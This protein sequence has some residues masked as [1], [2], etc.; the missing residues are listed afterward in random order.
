MAVA[1]VG[2]VLSTADAATGWSGVTNIDTD[3]EV[4]GTGCL[5]TKVSGATTAATFSSSQDLSSNGYHVVI[6]LNCTT[7]SLD[8]KANG[9]LR[10][11]LVDAGGSADWYVGGED[12]RKAGWGAYIIDPTSTANTGSITSS[13]ITALGGVISTV[14]TIMGNFNNGLWD[15]LTIGLG[16]RWTGTGGNFQSFVTADEGDKTNGKWGWVRTVASQSVILP[17]CKLY[18]GD[19]ST[20]T[21]FTDAG[22]ILFFEDAPVN[23]SFYE[24]QVTSNATFTLTD[25]SFIGIA[26]T[27][28]WTLTCV[29]AVT[30]QNSTL[31]GARQI[32]LAADTEI[33]NCVISNSGAI[34]APTSGTITIDLTNTSVRNSTATSALVWNVNENPGGNIDGMEFVS[35]GTGHAIELGTNSPTTINL[36]DQ[37]FSGY[38]TSNGS[39]GNEV[40]WIRRTTGTVTVY[41]SGVTGT[42]SY[43]TDGATVTLIQD[44]VTTLVRV[45]TASGTPISGA[46][47]YVIAG[48]GGPLTAGTVIINTTSDVNGEASDS[49]TLASDQPVTGWVRKSTSSPLYRQADINATIDSTVGVTITAL[50]ISDE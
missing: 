45:L 33:S 1:L 40:L 39:T 49:R 32:D 28:K 41:V 15:Q 38:A 10:I 37:I 42:V 22:A 13:A 18:I 44:P 29:G 5:G 9:G 30:I 23:A 17:Q 7:P 35:S 31:D 6:W 43:R 47:V 48:S 25:G 24:I 3:S 19:S 21:T 2:T 16:M 20:S 50:M 34:S 26:G 12:N 36:V 11:R 4:Q 27:A 46:R 14:S 8:L